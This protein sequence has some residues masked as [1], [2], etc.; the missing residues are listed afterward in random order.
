MANVKPHTPLIKFRAGIAVSVQQQIAPTAIL[1]A[2]ASVV[3]GGCLD[4]WEIPT[5]FRRE[6][7]DDL[8]CEA[9]NMGGREMPWC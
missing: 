3:A 2:L 8:E 7:I 1:G 9:I 5:K 6:S 4:W